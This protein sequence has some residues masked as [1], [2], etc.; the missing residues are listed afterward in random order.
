MRIK[1][2]RLGTKAGGRARG[3]IR[4]ARRAGHPTLP[5][6]SSPPAPGGAEVSFARIVAVYGDI[7]LGL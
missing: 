5:D 6:L 7:L 4:A 2:R 3:K 1:R